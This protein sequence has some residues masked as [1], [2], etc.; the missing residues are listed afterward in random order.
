MRRLRLLLVVGGCF[1]LL[2]SLFPSAARALPRCSVACTPTA[3]CSTQC[4]AIGGMSP[5][6]TT[7]GE[8]GICGG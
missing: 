3:S 6:I 2:L 1:G 8:W 4:V 5:E 7:C